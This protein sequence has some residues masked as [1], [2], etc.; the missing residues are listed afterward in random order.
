MIGQCV[1]ECVCVCVC[2]REREKLI[3]EEYVLLVI[4]CV[5]ERGRIRESYPVLTLN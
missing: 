1:C 3:E 2:V 4:G 5:M